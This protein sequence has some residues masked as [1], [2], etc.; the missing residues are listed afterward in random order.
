MSNNV[1]PASDLSERDV[2]QRMAAFRAA[3]TR[4]DGDSREAA[5]IQALADKADAEI[6]VYL[7][8]LE[9]EWPIGENLEAGDDTLGDVTVVGHLDLRRERT[10]ATSRAAASALAVT[11]THD[12]G[13]SIQEHDEV[14]IY[15]LALE[16]QYKLAM[17]EQKLAV[18][19]ERAELIIQKAE[20]E[21][22]ARRQKA[23]LK[24]RKKA[25]RREAEEVSP[26][27][28]SPRRSAALIPGFFAVMTG[29]IASF[30]LLAGHVSSA[31]TLI[32]AIPIAFSMVIYAMSI[33][34]A[35]FRLTD[36]DKSAPGAERAL[37]LLLGGW[38]DNAVRKRRSS[39][40]R[41]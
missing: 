5:R 22:E 3:L 28:S 8:E 29:V 10:G 21:A 20:A 18:A 30:A 38:A 36:P 13:I 40:N 19:S 35:V 24:A 7:D 41:Y 14:R 25:L 27:R 6:N 33:A 23:D 17:A 16:A 2:E 34:L 31:V 32:L 15:Q 37:H 39:A 26:P 12:P 4:V 11:G 9:D 1:K